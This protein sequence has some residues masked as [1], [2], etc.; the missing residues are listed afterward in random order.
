[1]LYLRE[2]ESFIY[3][4]TDNYDLISSKLEEVFSIKLV[5]T[6]KFDIIYSDEMKENLP[7]TR[8]LPR[9]YSN[10]LNALYNKYVGP[11]LDTFLS[12]SYW[13]LKK[14]ESTGKY[15]FLLHNPGTE[16]DNGVDKKYIDCFTGESH[17]RKIKH[18]HWI[19]IFNYCKN[20]ISPIFNNMNI[21]DAFQYDHIQWEQAHIKKQDMGT[22]INGKSYA[23]KKIEH[24]RN[25][26][27]YLLNSNKRHQEYAI[28]CN[29]PGKLSESHGMIDNFKKALIQSPLDDPNK[30]FEKIFILFNCNPKDSDNHKITDWSYFNS[31]KNNYWGY[32]HDENNTPINNCLEEKNAHEVEKMLNSINKERK[33]LDPSVV[34]HMRYIEDFRLFWLAYLS[35]IFREYT[36]KSD[37]PDMPDNYI[38]PVIR[39]THEVEIDLGP[40][41]Y[42]SSLLY[43]FLDPKNK[44]VRELVKN[45][46][47]SKNMP[48]K[49]IESLIGK[50][51]ERK[52]IRLNNLINI[53]KY[54]INFNKIYQITFIRLP[55]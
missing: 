24:C 17:R 30:F 14:E 44:E 41:C 28:T 50:Y 2:K 31:A 40:N 5:P 32:N 4:F 47:I 33:L 1:V 35:D 46:W 26:G 54:I 15:E 37:V 23:G 36:R 49:D 8:Y 53:L 20:E 19:K 34:V 11:Y 39:G 55:T 25:R 9:P 38:I 27:A 29:N 16:D 13:S 12:Q 18:H 3:C 45:A 10:P 48:D 43:N 6:E 52:H 42:Y 21:W 51:S 22:N 7:Y